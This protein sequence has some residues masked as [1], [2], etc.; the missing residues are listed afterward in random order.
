MRPKSI[1]SLKRYGHQIVIGNQLNSRKERV[2]FYERVNNDEDPEI[3]E[4]IIQLSNQDIDNG[5][6]IEKKIVARLITK[7]NQWCSNQ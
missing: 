1:E 3:I 2:V 5:I 6:E 7:H 4:E